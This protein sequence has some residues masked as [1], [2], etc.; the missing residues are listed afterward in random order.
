MWVQMLYFV[1][2]DP[3]EAIINILKNLKEKIA[4]Q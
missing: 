1:N 2:K 4:R 3:K